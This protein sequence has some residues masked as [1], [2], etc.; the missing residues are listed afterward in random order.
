MSIVVN[1]IQW[2]VEQIVMMPESKLHQISLLSVKNIIFSIKNSDIATIVVALW[3][4]LKM[5][6][7][8]SVNTLYLYN[9]VT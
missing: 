8:A 4:L 9:H 1:E 2:L 7:D 3:F 5:I 6:H